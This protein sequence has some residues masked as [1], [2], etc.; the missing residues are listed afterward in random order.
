MTIPTD[1]HDGYRR[2]RDARY[3][4]EERHYRQIAEG[5]TPQTMVIGCA[6]SRVDPATIFDAKPGELF[7]VRNIAALVPPFEEHGTYHGTS[8]AIE[9]AVTSLKVKRIVVLGHGL[10]GGISASL[11]AAEARPVGKFIGPWVEM[12]NTVRD[13]LLERG[14]PSDEATQQ[15][16]LEHMAIQQS[17]ENLLTFPFVA[18]AVENGT[19]AL[20]GAWFSIAEGKLQ[21]LDWDSGTFDDIPPGRDVAAVKP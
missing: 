14:G 7:V 8:A 13:E 3:A 4:H 16:A 17:L 1:L 21:W 20:E 12:L 5:Q 6:D 9:F 15:K 11:A 18:S 2:F 10:C 19:L